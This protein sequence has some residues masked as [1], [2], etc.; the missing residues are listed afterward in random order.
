MQ[1]SIKTCTIGLAC[2]AILAAT[3]PA[4]AQSVT[5]G[6]SLAPAD[7]WIGQAVGIGIAFA[8]PVGEA[9]HLVGGVGYH[10]PTGSRRW[11]C[12]GQ[13]TAFGRGGARIQ[14]SHRNWLFGIGAGVVVGAT[15]P[16]GLQGTL[17]TEALLTRLV[18]R[19][20]GITL[21]L[22]GEPDRDLDVSSIGL[23][24]TWVFGFGRY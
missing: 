22:L 2:A 19:S 6:A 24:V 15:G 12:D 9:M 13:R 20:V 11:R 21:T 5:G 4:R 8:D 1:T 10:C 23:G 7:N 17:Y 16:S 18:S 3:A 14:G